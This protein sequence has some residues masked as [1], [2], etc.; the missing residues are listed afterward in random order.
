MKFSFEAE[1]ELAS[2]QIWPFYAEVN[3]WFKWE[4]DLQKISLEGAF[5]T[6]TVGEMTLEGQPPMTFT[7]TSVKPNEHFTDETTIPGVGTISFHHE[8][9]SQGDKTLIRHSVEFKSANQSETVADSKFIAG[10]FSDV[11]ESVF[12]LMEAAK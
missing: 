6:G 4:D 8:L 5:E 3:N 2:E 11:P 10:I 9:E 7:L 12:S 1:T